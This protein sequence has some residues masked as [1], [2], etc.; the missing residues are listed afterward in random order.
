MIPRDRFRHACPFQ[1]CRDCATSL[2]VIV[3]K[4]LDEDAHAVFDRR[5]R[6]ETDGALQVSQSA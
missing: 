2:I 6:P 5:R 1:P 3:A 4:P